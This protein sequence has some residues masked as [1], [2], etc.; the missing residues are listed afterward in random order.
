M[1]YTHYIYKKP[2]IEDKTW[3]LLCEDTKTLLKSADVPLTYVQDEEDKY[4]YLVS[5]NQINFNGQGKDSHENVYFPKTT[6]PEESPNS[7]GKVFSFCKTARK[8]YD[9]YVTAFYL[10]AKFHMQEDITILSDGKVSDWQ[11]GLDLL[12][13]LFEYGATLTEYPEGTFDEEYQKDLDFAEIKFEY[14]NTISVD[15]FEKSL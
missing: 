9:K 13:N 10:L 7:Y 14:H 15:E 5:E 1:G 8:P 11:E 3:K 12:N 2:D 6:S 4:G